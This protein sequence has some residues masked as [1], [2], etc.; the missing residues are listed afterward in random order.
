MSELTAFA[1]LGFHH[2]VDPT[3][4]DHLLFLLALGPVSVVSLARLLPVLVGLVMPPAA[5]PT[6]TSSAEVAASASR[7]GA[8][9]PSRSSGSAPASSVTS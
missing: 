4:I 7:T 1:G 8:D 2:I 5:H 3:A 6:H 9:D